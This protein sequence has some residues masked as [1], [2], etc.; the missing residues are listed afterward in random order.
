MV[1]EFSIEEPRKVIIPVTAKNPDMAQKIFQEW[2]EKH[3]EDPMDTTIDE[4]L[5]NAYDG[6]TIRRSEGMDANDYWRIHSYYECPMQLPEEADEPQPP[7]YHLHIR[8]ADGGRSVD[9]PEID[10]NCIAT[11][12]SNFGMKY[13][14]Y[15]DT[16][17]FP[18]GIRGEKMINIYAALKDQE[19]TYYEFT[20]KEDLYFNENEKRE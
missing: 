15:P 20:Q 10:I 12:L 7:K 2:Y 3:T 1:Y 13:Y 6:R 17:A 19:E 11:I 14:L 4:M 5:E 8:F 16:D 9:Y 18:I